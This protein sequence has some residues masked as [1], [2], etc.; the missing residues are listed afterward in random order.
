MNMS[1]SLLTALVLPLAILASGI[2]LA[3]A[4]TVSTPNLPVNPGTGNGVSLS[5]LQ[6]LAWIRY[7]QGRAGSGG[8][9]RGVPQFVPFGGMMPYGNQM[10]QGAAMPMQGQNNNNLAG[11]ATD[12]NA[13]QAKKSA[14]EKKAEYAAAREEK[15]RKAQ[16]RA[17]KRKAELAARR[18]AAAGN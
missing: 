7:L 9:K 12:P 11:A 14:A 6:K 8:V 2:H 16:E 4:Q 15:K 1:Q 18:Q 17:E 10:N 13:G 5:Q 3:A